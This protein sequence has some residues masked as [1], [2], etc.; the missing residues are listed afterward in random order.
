MPAT[1]DMHRFFDLVNEANQVAKQVTQNGPLYLQ[2]L[3]ASSPK[4]G[5]EL[6]EADSSL[7]A[8]KRQFLS[9]S[10][11]SLRKRRR[12]SLD[13][14]NDYSLD[15]E[16]FTGSPRRAPAGSN[17]S[18]GDKLPPINLGPSMTSSDNS[19]LRLPSMNPPPT[20][21]RQLPSP[22]PY[23]LPSPSSTVF[24][25]SAAYTHSSL[26]PHPLSPAPSSSLGTSN[27][28]AVPP[29]VATHTAALQHEVSLKSYALQTLK[30]EHD[31][32][33]A[34]LSR[35]QTRARTLEEKQ[36]VADTEVNT[37]S[38]E[39]VRLLERIQELEQNVIEVGKARDEYRMAAVKEGKQYVE[40]VR[41]ASRLELMAGEERR[42]LTASLAAAQSGVS[43]GHIRN[44]DGRQMNGEAPIPESRP[45][46][47]N[48][49]R[50]MEEEIC[51]L[52]TRCANYEAALQDIT[53]ESGRIDE[54]IASLG[55][56]RAG[57]EKS[58]YRALGDGFQKNLQGNFAGQS[59]I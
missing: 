26:P 44:G 46:G 52:R 28:I 19:D 37:L 14:R 31:K 9:E 1:S 8:M 18:G 55:E 33:L 11:D 41:M 7:E 15:Q 39:R 35:S 6:N 36:I 32:L 42:R 21:G 23:N 50:A 13:P 49:D 53:Y 59:S 16:S 58:L 34:A 57:I 43:G 22:P 27:G 45:L 24:H 29:A 40:I 25:S 47:S 20:P 48:A 10:Q 30:S 4:R 51:H 54:V 12:D 17:L 3:K 38:E 56:T 2:K 5:S